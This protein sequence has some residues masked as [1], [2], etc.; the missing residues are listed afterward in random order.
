MENKDRK[1]KKKKFKKRKIK[2]KNK[3]AIEKTENMYLSKKGPE[4]RMKI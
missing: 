3:K 1:E 4:I 2:S